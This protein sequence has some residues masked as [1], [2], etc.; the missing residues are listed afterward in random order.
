M[1]NNL[2]NFLSDVISPSK[3]QIRKLRFYYVDPEHPEGIS[4]IFDLMS[5]IFTRTYALSKSGCDKCG[6][7]SFSI[8]KDYHI[9]NGVVKYTVTAKCKDCGN[10]VTVYDG[11]IILR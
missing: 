2:F 7:N 8:S 3:E 1:A 9:D 6:K 11:S 10:I 5:S 4:S